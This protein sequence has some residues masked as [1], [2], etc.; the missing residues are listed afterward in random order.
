M[1]EAQARTLAAGEEVI[2]KAS[3]ALEA[4]GLSEDDQVTLLAG[5]IAS[6]ALVGGWPVVRLLA[7]VARAYEFC[8]KKAKALAG[9]LETREDGDGEGRRD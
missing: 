5:M 7:E 6:R 9:R 4:S 8:Y 3:D 1:D 2:R